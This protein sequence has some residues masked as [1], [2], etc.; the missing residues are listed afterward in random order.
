MTENNKTEAIGLI[1]GFLT[2]VSFVPQLSKLWRMKP[3]PAPNISIEMY[4]VIVA[5][6][7]FWVWYG[8][9]LRARAVIIWN[10]VSFMLTASI[11]A[12][13]ITCG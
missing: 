4:I 10:V 7:A 1:G 8:V 11:L 12:Y 5:G 13:K 9:R 3:S 2:T 6:V